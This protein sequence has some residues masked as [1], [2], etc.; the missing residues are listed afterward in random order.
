MNKEEGQ[1]RIEAI[2]RYPKKEAVSSIQKKSKSRYPRYKKSKTYNWMQL[3]KK[4]ISPKLYKDYKN[5]QKRIINKY[6]NTF[7]YGGST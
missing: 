4:R 2:T 7:E 1:L 6:Y 3:L 5:E